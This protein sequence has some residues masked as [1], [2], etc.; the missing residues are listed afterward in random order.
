MKILIAGLKKKP[1]FL[2]IKE[3]AEKRG[4]IVEGCLASD[5]VILGSTDVFRPFLKDGRKLEEYDLI[6]MFVGKRLWEWFTAAKY[7]NSKF[8]T[9]IVNGKSIDPTYNYFQTPVIDYLRQT[10]NKIPYPKSALVFSD[11]ALESIEDEF[12]FPVIVKSTLGHG[13]KGVYL[14]KTKNELE[15]L[16]FELTEEIKSCVIR[17]FIPNDGDL[18]VFCVGYKAIG[19]MKRTPKKGDFRS[20]VSQ[21]GSAKR[22]DLSKYPNIK[23]I[24]EETAKVMRVEVAGVDIMIHK[25]TKK[26][27]VLEINLNPQIAGIE[28]T[29]LNVAGEIVKYFEKLYKQ[30]FQDKSLKER[31]I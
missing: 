6:Y 5:L 12:T 14:A 7:I 13:G 29:G 15:K 20:N 3:E 30:S 1:Q 24:A 8:G 2:R 9:I 22:F 11:T 28:S 16:V 18:R 26:P 27:Y 4:H 21:G 19:A 17:E 31:K 23:S 25:K 10:E